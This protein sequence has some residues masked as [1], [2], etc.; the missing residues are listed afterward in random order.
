MQK[1]KF[2]CP[3]HFGLE[4]VLSFEV[5]QLGGEDVTAT[6]GKVSFSGGLDLLARA[7]LSLRTAERVLIVLGE[8]TA[9]SFEELFQGVKAIAW[10]EFIPRQDA[11]PVKGHSL[12][13]TLHSVPDCQA[14]TKKAVVE[15]LK[16]KYG[17]S[18]FTETGAMH[19]IQFSI[20]KDN[21]TIM[22]DT[23]GA[24]LHKRGYRQNAN[25]APIK[26]TLAAGIVDLARI[27]ADSMVCDPFC[28]SGTMLI[29]AAYKAMNIAPCINRK[30]AAEH[31]DCIP[32]EIWRQERTRAL[33]L[34]RRDATFVAYGSDIDSEAIA[35]TLENAKK[36]GIGTRIKAKQAA[37]ADFSYDDYGDKV[38][39]LCN[40]PY[41]ERMLELKQAEEIYAKLGELL[42]PSA[43]RPFYVITADEDFERVFGHKAT[44]RRKL[45]NGMIRCQLYMYF[46]DEMKG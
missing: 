20:I 36:A 40:P 25:A 4:S 6:D 18:W 13:S 16:A 10:E 24:G 43:D 8:F 23:S 19:Q 37:I 44:K 32:Q 7:N 9:R 2:S 26:E 29:E 41:G 5:K 35:L 28:G 38:I 12:N 21:V 46:K 14:I 1:L 39:M 42:H 11:F 27:R 31:W 30:F 22:L 3:C 45:Y 33:D 17:V 15:R 34:V